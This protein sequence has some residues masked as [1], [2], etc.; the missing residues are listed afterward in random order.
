MNLIFETERLRLREFTLT[1][2][3]FIV[4]LLNTSGWL[5]YIG[6]RN[7]RTEKQAIAYLE[8]GPVRSY[9][10]HGFGLSAVELKQ[11]NK[12]IGMCGI[13]KRDTLEHPDIGFAFL[14]DFMGNGYAYEIASTTLAYANDTLHLPIICAITD[15]DN[16]SSIRLL[17][18]IRMTFIKTFRFP[19]TNE[20]LLLFCN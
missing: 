2:T 10:E 11:E 13:L 8:N 12:I 3:A 16:T 14:P 18:K 15:P 5:K 17:E 4:E 1:D 9:R 20:E 6:D 19:G 7:V